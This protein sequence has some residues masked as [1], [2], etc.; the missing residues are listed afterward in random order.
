[1]NLDKLL[2][3][4]KDGYE[5]IEPLIE[6]H[7]QIKQLDLNIKTIKEEISIYFKKLNK[8]EKDLYWEYLNE[9]RKLKTNKKV[10]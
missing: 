1:M 10:K 2:A 4:A 5:K 7:N 9:V 6:K 8:F 3:K